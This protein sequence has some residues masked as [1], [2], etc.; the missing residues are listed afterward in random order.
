[1]NRKITPLMIFG[2][3][4]LIVVLV[5]W[6]V[7]PEWKNLRGGLWI[8]IGVAAV[9]VLAFLKDG[10]GLIKTWMETQS[11]EE[12]AALPAAEEAPEE[13]DS[14]VTSVKWEARDRDLVS[15]YFEMCSKYDDKFEQYTKEEKQVEFCISFGL[16]RKVGRQLFLTQA[17]A[18]LFCRQETFP[19][20]SLHA[21]VI[22][23][24]EERPGAEVEQKKDFSG[25]IL[26]TYF[27]IHEILKPLTTAWKAA[28]IRNPNGQEEVFFYYPEVAV[29]E[30]LV[31][32]FIHRD[33]HQDD[34]GY[35]T[36]YSDRIEFINPG[37]SLFS[38]EELL[39]TNK[40]LRP[41]YQRNPRLL[42][43]LR[44]TGLNQSEGRGILRTRNSLI[45]NKTIDPDG[46]VGLFIENDETM[47]RFRLVMYK[48]IPAP[49]PHV[50]SRLEKK[51]KILIVE[52][53]LDNAEMLN[54]Y[55][56]VQG[57]EVYTV[58]WGED[59][60]K[61][62]QSIL[63]DLIILDIRLPDIDG[64]EVARRLRGNRHSADIPIIFL[65]EKRD[66]SDR[67]MGLELGA[68]DYITKP[69]DVQELRL[70]V[71][72]ALKRASFDTLINPITNLPEGALTEERLYE[73]MTAEGEEGLL[74]V[75]IRHMDAFRELYGFVASDDVLR[76]AV[77]MISNLLH[78]D[79]KPEDFIGHLSMTDLI[80]I[81]PLEKL[82]GVCE[83]IQTRLTS[84]AE[85]FYPIK[86]REKKAKEKDSL[87]FLV[88]DITPLLHEYATPKDL[89]GKIVEKK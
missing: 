62:G 30:L 89:I 28:N 33:Y 63:P 37:K 3:L 7:I 70:R 10:V 17:G 53:D 41:P 85:Y 44:K 1:M 6:N 79:G 60:V 19:H 69:F 31:N 2:T 29:T 66:R 40:P 8:L 18:L 47:N 11:L 55:F 78:E 4:L 43:T 16:V 50:T 77:M 42:Q 56:R 73:A 27:Q 80:L 25:A 5:S 38:A 58:N 26:E 83:K 76:A 39:N 67:L 49:Y 48:K 64:Y 32:F 51:T 59:G 14:R 15:K 20:A 81:L 87:G 71:R 12:E 23:R 86:D 21:D 22:F 75:S 9:G 68:D 35:I 24:N 46:K 72:N 57:Y 52:D 84:S 36:V 88:S 13:A 74:F 54:A 61:A 65:T 45:K 82:P 34:I